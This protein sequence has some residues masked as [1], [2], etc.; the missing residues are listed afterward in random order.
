MFHDSSFTLRRRL[1]EIDL[2]SRI[3]RRKPVLKPHHIHA[4]LL[5]ARKHV[6]LTIE[7]WIRVIWSDECFIILH[8]SK[9]SMKT[10]HLKERSCI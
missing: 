9:I 2:F 6:N 10:M 7:Q 5:W 4:R 8:R 3:R 1:K